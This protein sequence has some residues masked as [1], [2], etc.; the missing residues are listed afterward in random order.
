MC[1]LCH[2]HG[3]SKRIHRNLCELI[4]VGWGGC[5]QSKCMSVFPSK[6][7]KKQLEIQW[8]IGPWSLHYDF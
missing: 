1:R 2:H 4:A 3:H 8:P 6:P 7:A 5:V